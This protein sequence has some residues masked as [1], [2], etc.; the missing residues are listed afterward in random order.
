MMMLFV[1]SKEKVRE[2]NI[3]VNDVLKKMTLE[4]KVGQ[5]CVPILQSDKITEEI[6]KAVVDYKVGVVRY[7]PDAEFDNASVAVGEPNKYFT[8]NESAEFLNRLQS[9]A[10]IPLI[11]SVDQEGGCRS[12]VNRCNAMVY[13]SHMCFG[14]ADDPELTY[15]VAKATAEEFRAMG[16][17]QIQSPICDVFRYTGRKTMKAAT[18][19]EDAENVA[20]H[21]VAM[22]RGFQDGGVLSMGKHFP[23]YGSIATDAHKGTAHIVKS[24]KDL[25]KEDIVPFKHLID[26][27]VDG[28]MMGHV[29]VDAIDPH[30]PA[31]LSRILTTGYVREKLGFKGIIMT[32]AMRMKAIQDNYG[33]GVASVM[34]IKAGCDLVLLRGDFNHFKDG[35]NAILEAAKSGDIS[36]KVLDES[37]LRILRAK[38]KIGLFNNRYADTQKADMVVG[39]EEH[40]Q[41]LFELASKSI[42]VL[43]EKNLPLAANDGK[44]ISVISVEPQKIAAAMDE[45]Q[46]VDMLEKE[47]RA[48]HENTDGIVI[49]LDPDNED[50]QKAVAVAKNA[51]IIVLGMCSGIIFTNQE[52]LYRELKVLGKPLIIVAME[53]PCDIELVPDCANYIATYGAAR[54]WMK[55]AAMRIFG[56]TDINAKPA[57]TIPGV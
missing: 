52:R 36:E 54:D 41:L 18:F 14:V 34:A 23:G 8:P 25:E 13:A 5:M 55:V 12:D 20:K 35:Y 2:E 17:N 26:D 42:S 10:E 29:I 27:G 37:V 4:E 28:I 57:I 46:C 15:Q 3:M 38:E 11:I 43:R 49:K 7:C 19:G 6:R 16:I 40:K 47:I 56:L 21:V 24:V 50:I 31:T 32:D 45:K 9:L 30:V 44:K 1:F 33:T 22:K 48:I 51:D 39:R 53:S